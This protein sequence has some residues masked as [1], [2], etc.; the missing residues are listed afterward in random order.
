MSFLEKPS[1]CLIHHLPL[2][3]VVIV[4]GGPIGLLLVRVLSFYGVNSVLFERNE[5]TSKWPKMDLTNG[6]LMEIFR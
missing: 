5:S 2:G 1:E 3:Y 6:R 4:G